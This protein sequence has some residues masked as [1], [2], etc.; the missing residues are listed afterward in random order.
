MRVHGHL[1]GSSHKRVELQTLRAERKESSRG[2]NLN[3]GRA[4]FTFLR[5]LAGGSH[6]RQLWSSKGARESWQ[7][8]KDSTLQVPEWSTLIPQKTSRHVMRLPWLNR[9]LLAEL[10]HKTGSIQEVEAGT[11]CNGGI[12]QQI[13]GEC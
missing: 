9:Q 4:H 11:S 12:L 6:R 7:V 8:F 13:L 10:Q 2:Q 5:D 3:F 1:G